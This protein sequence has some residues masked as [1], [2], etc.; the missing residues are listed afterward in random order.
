MYQSNSDAVFAVVQAGTAFKLCSGAVTLPGGLAGLAGAVF[1]GRR[2]LHPSSTSGKGD[3]TFLF[4]FL[5][6]QHT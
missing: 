1:E 2:L 4:V 6:L 5:G 3:S